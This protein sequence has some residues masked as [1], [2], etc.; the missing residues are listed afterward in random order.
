MRPEKVRIVDGRPEPGLHVERGRVTD[1]SY[2]GPLT[3]YVVAL[4]RGGELQAVAQNLETT[5]AEALG[6]K[7]REISVA[8][9]PEH[10]SAIHEEGR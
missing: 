8:W 7:G 6:Q 3:R 2:A 4:E 1:V 5:S 10:T 9:R